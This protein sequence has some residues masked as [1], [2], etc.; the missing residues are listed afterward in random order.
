MPSYAFTY[1]Q[2]GSGAATSPANLSL[3]L[4]S[5]GVS[6]VEL[7]YATNIVAFQAPSTLTSTLTSITAN[8]NILRVDTG[9]H[10]T[11][12][13]V[14]TANASGSNYGNSSVFTCNTAT[15]SAAPE[16]VMTANGL[17]SVWLDRIRKN[18]LN[19]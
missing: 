3:S 16:Q 11:L 10:G 19:G 7:L 17:D 1:G 4:S 12:F 8:G 5:N 14:I 13:A 18:N 15:T 9:Y 6:A 2:V